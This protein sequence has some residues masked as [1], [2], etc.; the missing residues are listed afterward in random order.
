MQWNE[1]KHYRVSEAVLDLDN[2]IIILAINSVPWKSTF[3]SMTLDFGKSDDEFMLRRHGRLEPRQAVATSSGAATS[4]VAYPAA[5]S[6]TPSSWNSSMKFNKQWLDTSILPADTSLG[7][8][9]ANSPKLSV[10][11]QNSELGPF[12]DYFSDQSASI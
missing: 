8:L 4:S 3:K 10:D 6:S 5:P 2:Q 1:A 9:S 12:S 7:K 11:F